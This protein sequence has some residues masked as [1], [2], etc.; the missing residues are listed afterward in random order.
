M[1]VVERRPAARAMPAWAVWV[2]RVMSGLVVAFLL[3][4]GAIKVLDLAIVA[5]TLNQLGFPTTLARGLGVLTLL[6]AV[7]YGLPRTAFLGAVLLTGLLG[8]AMAT[9]LRVG[10]PLFTHLL[11]GLYI[12]VLAWGGLWLR[13]PKLRAVVRGFYWRTKVATGQ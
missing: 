4:D 9:H 5:E 2:G 8:G 1:R 3:M 7:L 12:G 10:N 13:D 6:I 11:F